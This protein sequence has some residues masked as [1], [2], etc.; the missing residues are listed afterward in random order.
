MRVCYLALILH[1]YNHA[2]S[3]ASFIDFI[4]VLYCNIKRN[5]LIIVVHLNKTKTVT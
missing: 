2:Y 3:E 5:M 1:A 4:G